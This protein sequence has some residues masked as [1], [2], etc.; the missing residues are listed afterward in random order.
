M[1]HIYNLAFIFFMIISQLSLAETIN[2]SESNPRESEAVKI[3]NDWLNIVENGD[4]IQ[5]F[6]MLAP[7]FQKNLTQNTWR[8]SVLDGVAKTGK[9]ISRRL[10]RVVWYDNPE[11]APLPGLYVAIEFDSIFENTDKHFQFIILHSQNGE[12]FK[13]MRKEVD[14]TLK[15]QRRVD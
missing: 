15:S 4:D 7:I 3:A 10:R 12:P 14:V 13:I 1:R 6:L 5:S 9:L 8:E 11:N 2:N